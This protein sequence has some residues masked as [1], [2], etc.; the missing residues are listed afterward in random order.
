MNAVCFPHGSAFIWLI[1]IHF[2]YFRYVGD[3][4]RSEAVQ[5]TA[6]SAHLSTLTP[7]SPDDNIKNI[8]LREV[9]CEMHSFTFAHFKQVEAEENLFLI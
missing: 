7:P 4:C 8:R 5:K 9:V 6:D 3:I 2:G 1:S